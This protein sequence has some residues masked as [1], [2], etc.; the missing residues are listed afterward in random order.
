MQ[1]Q[2]QQKAGFLKPRISKGDLGDGDDPVIDSAASVK[3]SADM[4]VG[5]GV[6]GAGAE[7]TSMTSQ[8]KWNAAPK[9]H[10]TIAP[11]EIAEQGPK[12]SDHQ[13]RTQVELA[14]NWQPT[15]RVESTQR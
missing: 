8:A 5:L 9:R 11:C 13:Y 14:H 7:T 6:P 12:E 10:A 1:R 2:E 15:T 4:D 3:A